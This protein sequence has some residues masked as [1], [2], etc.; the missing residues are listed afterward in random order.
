MKKAIQFVAV[1]AVVA[2]ASTSLM[3]AEGGNARKGKYLYKKS[4]K[5]CHVD[6]AAGGKLTPMSKTQ[7]QW[8]RF[9]DRDKHE[10]NPDAWSKFSEQD[11]KDVQQ[12]LYDHALDSDQPETC[13]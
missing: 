1:L 5:S 13:G 9:F 7:G 2:M 8:D 4:C 10:K 3:A 6:G 11:I 12:Y